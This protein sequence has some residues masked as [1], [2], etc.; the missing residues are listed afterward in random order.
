MF[1]MPLDCIV[2]LAN[3]SLAV[4]VLASSF[5][6]T[7]SIYQEIRGGTKPADSHISANSAEQA[8]QY[9]VR[10]GRER[11]D[12]LIAEDWPSAYLVTR[13]AA[14]RYPE[15]AGLM[16][17]WDSTTAGMEGDLPLMARKLLTALIRHGGESIYE[18]DMTVRSEALRRLGHLLEVLMAS[19][20]TL[21]EKGIT[22]CR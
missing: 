3:L 19:C 16:L 5:S 22:P 10:V 2:F 11:A 6:I 4:F 17:I 20:S 21:K 18:P 7:E 14:L 13:R 1:L 8:H 12:A 9:W 15:S